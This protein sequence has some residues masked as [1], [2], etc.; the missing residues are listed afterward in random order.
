[1]PA[2][3]AAFLGTAVAL[4]ALG[5]VVLCTLVVL[6]GFTPAGEDPPD[7]ANRRLL[8]TRVG[9]AIAAVCFT[10]TAILIAVVLV[11]PGRPPAPVAATIQAPDGRLPVLGQQLAGQEKRLLGQ[12]ARLA[13]QES[14]LA[15]TETRLH[16]LENQLRRREAEL[17][18]AEAERAASVKASAPASAKAAV[19]PP[20]KPAAPAPPKL[21]PPSPAR[22]FEEMTLREP[23]PPP[24]ASPRAP[25]PPA[26]PPAP[27]SHTPTA[28]PVVPPPTPVAA[29]PARSASPEDSRPAPAAEPSF[30]L[31]NKLKQDWRDI[32]RGVSSAGDDFRDAVD[33]LKRHLLGH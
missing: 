7:R 5:A 9:H 26:P 1:M 16:E 12:E 15:E 20:A 2:F 25:D 8:L 33:N 28:M 10:A 29:A 30:N 11:A 19:P 31:S 6:Y 14:R 4:S 3:A 23:S 24:A 32:Q 27:P 22:P 18:R 17:A 13:G 21:G